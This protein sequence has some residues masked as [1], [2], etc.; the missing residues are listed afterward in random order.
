MAL[1]LLVFFACE[2]QGA[3]IRWVVSGR[4]VSFNQYYS[5]SVLTINKFVGIIFDSAIIFG[6]LLMVDKFR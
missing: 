2:I 6:Y 1:A 4:R 5:Q 3:F